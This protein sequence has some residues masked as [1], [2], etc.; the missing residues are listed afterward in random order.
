[1][2]FNG[3]LQKARSRFRFGATNWKSPRAARCEPAPVRRATIVARYFAPYC[4]SVKVTI[5]DAP[6]TSLTTVGKSVDL[7][8]NVTV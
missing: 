4:R 2:S 1:M 6:P 5:W 3:W 7:G 8:V